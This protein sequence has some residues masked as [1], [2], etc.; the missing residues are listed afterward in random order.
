MIFVTAIQSELS[1]GGAKRDVEN[2]PKKYPG[3]TIPFL[4]KG[5]TPPWARADQHCPPRRE[6]TRLLNAQSSLGPAPV[7]RHRA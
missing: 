3:P 7:G 2:T 5:P 4:N 1:A 6:E